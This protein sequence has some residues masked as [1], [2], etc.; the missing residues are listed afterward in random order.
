MI[1]LRLK[2]DVQNDRKVI[3]TLPPDVP[4]GRLSPP[5]CERYNEAKTDSS[6]MIN[7]QLNLTMRSRLL[8][9]PSV[10]Q[11]DACAARLSPSQSS[12]MRPL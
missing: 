7:W 3:V 4:T 2:A 5:S 9:Q 8:P 12:N 1:T 11:G 6:A 10:C